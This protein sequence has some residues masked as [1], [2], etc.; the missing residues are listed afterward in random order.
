MAIGVPL[1]TSPPWQLTQERVAPHTALL[2]PW[3]LMLEQVL[4]PAVQVKALPLPACGLMVPLVW[5]L[6]ARIAVPL[7]VVPAWQL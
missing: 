3:Q 7:V 6:P 2:P 1:A 4:V 5:P